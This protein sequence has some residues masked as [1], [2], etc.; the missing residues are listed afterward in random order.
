MRSRLGFFCLPGRGHL[1][2]GTALGRHL[3]RRGFSVTFFNRSVAKAIVKASGLA[4]RSLCNS[5]TPSAERMG[6]YDERFIGPHP[7]ETIHAHAM[8][9]LKFAKSA[10]AEEHIDALVVDQADLAAGS[11]ADA[12]GIPFVN[13]SMFPPVYLNDDSPPFI[14]D[15]IP[16][17]KFDDCPRNARGNKLFRQLFSPTV[18]AINASRR[19]WGMSAVKDINDLFSRT[20]I[21]SQLPSVLDFPRTTNVPAL[22]HTGQF[23]DRIGRPAVTFPWSRLNGKPIVYACMGTVRTGSKAVFETIASACTPFD[24]QLVISLGGMSLTPESLGDLPGDPIVVHFAPQIDLLR[25]SVL[26][27]TH[28]GMNTVLEAVACGI[29]LVAIPV[30]DDQPG[31][32]ARIEWSGIGLLLPFRRISVERLRETIGAVLGDTTFSKNVRGIQSKIQGVEGVD[33]AADV[34]EKVLR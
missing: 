5:T 24:I 32:A 22:F 2:P 15:W 12:L 9:V 1:Y 21:I 27:I 29:P 17:P 19:E 13:V 30:T 8:F 11:V 23:Y 33:I 20:A 18:D 6:S 14:F 34:I 10:V 7:V 25:R 4:F 3:K 28:G 26:C 31:V 16:R